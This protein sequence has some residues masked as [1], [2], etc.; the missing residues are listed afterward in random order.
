[1]WGPVSLRPTGSDP[2]LVPRGGAH[3]REG[4][5]EVR[6][7]RR[8]ELPGA[9]D[10]GVAGSAEL[11]AAFAQGVHG[12]LVDDPPSRLN[13][14]RLK[15]PRSSSRLPRPSMKPSREPTFRAALMSA[16]SRP[17]RSIPGSRNSKR[18]NDCPPC[19][20]IASNTTGRS[21]SKSNTP[22]RRRSHI[23]SAGD[24][25]GLVVRTREVAATGTLAREPR[26]QLENRRPLGPSMVRIPS[27]PLKQPS[28]GLV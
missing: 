14:P 2:R 12:S 22:C 19:T 28:I 9:L 24:S 23:V 27:P 15:M 8:V 17:G 6:G 7:D 26:A 21:C 25:I 18:A 5:A 20:S 11:V 10:V 16:P 13:N 4:S 3:G 1:V